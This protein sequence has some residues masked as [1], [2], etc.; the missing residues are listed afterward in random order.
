MKQV[1]LS[2]VSRAH[3]GKVDARTSRSQELVP[4][5]VYGGKEQKHINV[6]Y[7]EIH[8]ILYS[9]DVY[10]INLTIDGNTYPTIVREVQ[11]HPVTDKLMHVDF[12]ELIPGKEVVVEIPLKFVGTSP[13]VLAG[14]KLVKSMRKVKVKATAENMPEYV[15]VDISNLNLGQTLKVKNIELT[16]AKLVDVAERAVAAVN[17]TRNT[18]AAAADAA[19]AK[20]AKK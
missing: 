2:G 16:G 8:K 17:V 18:Q 6:P 4:A 3:V 20:G 11:F 7:M 10:Q 13:G 1:S 15:S 12:F 14:G 5:V 9:P 19:P